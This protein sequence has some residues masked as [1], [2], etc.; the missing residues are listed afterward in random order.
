VPNLTAVE[1]RLTYPSWLWTL[2]WSSQPQVDWRT[3]GHLLR[4]TVTPLL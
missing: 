1:T 3:W 2:R 4:W